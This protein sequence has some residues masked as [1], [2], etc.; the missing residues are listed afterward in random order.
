MQISDALHLRNRRR[1]RQRP[2]PG[3]SP[4]QPRQGKRPR[5]AEAGCSLDALV[6]DHQMLLDRVHIGTQHIDIGAQ[7]GNAGLLMQIAGLHGD[8]DMADTR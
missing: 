5:P 2:A 1:T 4:E 7:F 8:E 3:S 6:L